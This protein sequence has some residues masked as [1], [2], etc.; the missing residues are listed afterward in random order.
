MAVAIA[1]S[2]A[3][4]PDLL[5]LP[6]TSVFTSVVR[7]G[8]LHRQRVLDRASLQPAVEQKRAVT[9]YLLRSSRTNCDY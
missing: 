6:T 1:D 3:S 8:D 4:E 9:S 5:E 7:S 2:M